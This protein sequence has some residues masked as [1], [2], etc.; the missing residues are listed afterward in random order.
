[1]RSRRQRGLQPPVLLDSRLLQEIGDERVRVER[2]EI[3]DPLTQPDELNRDTEL[4]LDRD[5]DAPFAVPSSLVSTMPLIGTAA[6]NSRT[7][8]TP[9]CPPVASRT[10]S[11]SSTSPRSPEATRWIF[12]NSAI[13]FFLP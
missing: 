1:M 4:T 7:W 3:V 12:P 5:D 2:H 6:E 9:F 11:T 8:V 10:S 13:R